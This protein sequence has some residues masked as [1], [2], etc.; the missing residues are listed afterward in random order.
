MNVPYSYL[1]PNSQS[2][3]ASFVASSTGMLGAYAKSIDARSFISVDYSRVIPAAT[4]QSYSFKIKPGGEPQLWVDGAVLTAPALLTFYVN[5]GIGGRAY[6]VTINAKQTNGEIRTDLLNVQILD[7][8]CGCPSVVPSSLL[9]NVISGV[10]GIYSNNAPKLYVG[11]VAPVGANVLDQWFDTTSGNIYEYISDGITNTWRLLSAGTGILLPTN[12]ATIVKLAPIAA[13][14]AT[15][16]FTLR[17][18]LGQVVNIGSASDVLVSVDGIWQEPFIQYIAG[19]A[20]ITFTEAPSADSKVFMIWF[21]PP[22]P[23]LF[24]PGSVG[25]NIVKMNPITPDGVT[26]IFTLVASDGSTV[27]VAGANYLFVSVDGVWQ[28]PGVHYTAS[29][30]LISF[31]QAPDTDASVFMLWFAPTSP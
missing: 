24:D 3:P 19:S 7:D 26:T 9:S 10:S 20:Q 14:G 22:A 21:M 17:T 27:N 29:G 28:E 6:E 18:I 11:G 8:D 31:I 25:A 15:T 5:G 4:L 23:T 12:V 1:I 2:D 30:T 13:D 16:T